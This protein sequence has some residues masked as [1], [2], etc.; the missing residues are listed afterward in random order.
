MMAG[1]ASTTDTTHIS[2][3]MNTTLT[4]NIADPSAFTVSGVASNP[5]V[6]SASISGS[7][8]TLTL[9]KPINYSDT[10]VKVSYAKTGTTNLTTLGTGL[11]LDN[12][13][14]MGITNN[15]A[16][17][18]NQSAPT[19]LTGDIIKQLE[20]DAF[21]VS[22]TKDN[23]EYVLPAAEIT[24]EKVADI[25]TVNSDQ[26][27]DI[28]VE[29]RI[30]E[31]SADVLAKYNQIA[32]SQEHVFVAPP[33]EFEIVAKA[34]GTDGVTRE[35][36]VSQF[37]NYVERIIEIPANVDPSKITTGVV[38]NADGTYSHVP[39]VVFKKVASIML[40]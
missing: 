6:T 33:V 21:K 19:G 29:V 18:Q 28:E 20:D 40:N 34:T 23:V 39:T 27:K 37:S 17:N 36:T 2:I 7:N 11:E 10:N 25:L 38:F 9:D 24:I 13:T 8:I 30:K 1:S 4:G 35:T 22:I 26:L 14:E 32:K 3:T 15:V 12:F 5:A 16:P 31:V